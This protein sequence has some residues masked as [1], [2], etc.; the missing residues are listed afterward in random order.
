MRDAARQTS[1]CLEFRP[2]RAQTRFSERVLGL[3][4]SRHIA[5]QAGTSSRFRR[6]RVGR[7]IPATRLFRHRRSGLHGT[8][9]FRFQRL[10]VDVAPGALRRLEETGQRD[11]ARST[12]QN[13]AVLSGGR[14]IDIFDSI[15]A[16]DDKDISSAVLR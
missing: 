2:L 10:A 8:A 7:V 15:F 1:E 6:H 5:G 4:T 13:G 12:V 3:F 11:A 16:V 14:G 9:E